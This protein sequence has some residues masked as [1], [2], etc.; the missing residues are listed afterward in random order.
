MRLLVAFTDSDWFDYLAELRP[1][2]VKFLQPSV[3]GSFQALSS[4]EP[5]HFKLHSPD[6]FIQIE[7]YRTVGSS[8]ER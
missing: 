3:S 2:E 8:A 1:D 5:L 7:Q 4:G 6:C